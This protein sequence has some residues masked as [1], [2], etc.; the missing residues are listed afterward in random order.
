MADEIM[1][2]EF[3]TLTD[4]EGNESRFELIGSVE[5]NENT[6]YALVPQDDSDEYVI[7]KLTKD[8]NGEDIL[9]TRSA[10]MPRRAVSRSTISNIGDAR[11]I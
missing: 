5:M 10:T 2:G 7:L 8:E 4:E 6:Y 3:Y 11:S 1:E 9:I